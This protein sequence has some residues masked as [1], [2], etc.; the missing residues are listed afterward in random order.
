M[1]TLTVE[2]TQTRELLDDKEKEPNSLL[3]LTET[4]NADKTLRFVRRQ[5]EDPAI[6]RLRVLG[7][8][9]DTP[10]KIVLDDLAETTTLCVTDPVSAGKS[11]NISQSCPA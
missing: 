10:E 9:I 8:D 2:A 1:Y 11:E 6:S 4:V 5:E 7:K 3:D